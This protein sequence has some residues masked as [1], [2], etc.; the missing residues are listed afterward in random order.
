M[1]VVLCMVS[2]VFSHV[3]YLMFGVKCQALCLVSLVGCFMSGVLWV[4]KYVSPVSC[5]LS[6]VLYFGVWC[7]LLYVLCLMSGVLWVIK[8]VPKSLVFLVSYGW[9]N[10]CLLSPVFC[11]VSGVSCLFS[12][13]WCLMSCS[14]GYNVCCFMPCVHCWVSCVHRVKQ[15]CLKLSFVS[16]VLLDVS[17]LVSYRWYMCLLSVILKYCVYFLKCSLS[18]LLYVQLTLI[19]GLPSKFRFS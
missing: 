7:V 5:L 11:L 12:F 19:Q 4:I 9:W 14:L 6:H 2:H 15:F 10:M 17:C 18:L 13:V 16:F 8:Y 3:L 1:S